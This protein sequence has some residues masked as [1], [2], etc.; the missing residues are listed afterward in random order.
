MTTS[1]KA[2]VSEDISELKARIEA[3]EAKLKAMEENKDSQAKAE[4]PTEAA[5]IVSGQAGSEQA[6]SEQ[7]GSE[8]TSNADDNHEKILEEARRVMNSLLD[9]A[10]AAAADSTESFSSFVN[11]DARP[12]AEQ[13]GE[14]LVNVFSKG[15]ELQEKVLNRFKEQLKATKKDES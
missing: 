2:P 6:G 13:I 10:K 4:P 7:A 3:M 12:S 8:H 15:I 14:T 9:A 5:E 1:K 11:E